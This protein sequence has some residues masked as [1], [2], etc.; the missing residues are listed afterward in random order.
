MAEVEHYLY[1]WR[2]RREA[3]AYIRAN[4]LRVVASAMFEL[5]RHA[6]LG[7][8]CCAICRLRGALIAA[9]CR[10]GRCV[11][12]CLPAWPTAEGCEGAGPVCPGGPLVG[13]TFIVEGR[14]YTWQ[15]PAGTLDIALED[16]GRSREAHHVYPEGICLTPACRDT[17]MAVVY[18][19]LCL[20]QPAPQRPPWLPTLRQALARDLGRER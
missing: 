13:L 6:R 3:R 1:W 4:S 7:D 15:Q 17:L 16:T 10:Q 18:E 5:D 8:H 2:L 12:A 9:F 11:D 19:Y 20:Q 14:H